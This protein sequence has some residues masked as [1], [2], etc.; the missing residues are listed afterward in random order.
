[1]YIIFFSSLNSKEKKKVENKLNFYLLKN[2][3][4]LCKEVKNKDYNIYEF[5][6]SL[7]TKKI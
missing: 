6:H 5:K 4:V 2:F 7:L 1:M 3:S